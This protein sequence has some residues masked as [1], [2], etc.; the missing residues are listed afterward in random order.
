MDTSKKHEIFEIE[1]LDS[2]KSG[3]F[4]EP[5]VFG[6][7]TM[8]RLC[9]ELNRYSVDLDFWFIRK[10]DY[11]TYFKKLRTYLE[12]RYDLTY[13]Q[14][15]SNILLFE[16]RSKDYQKRLKIEIRREIKSCDYQEKIA[17]SKC[18]TKQ[19]LL[20][21][22]TLEQTMKNKIEAALDRAEIRDFFDIEFM[23]RNGIPLTATT[24]QKDLMAKTIAGFKASD[25][26]VKLG[27]LLDPETRRYYTKNQFDYLLNKLRQSNP[28]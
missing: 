22:H 10:T 27:A 24:A 4:L 16:I 18:H 26:S 17:F 9:Y 5:L 8:L 21:V 28:Q 25:Y 19:V 12:S 6:G 7:G 3:K 2:L 15:K 23:L 14:T 13:A 1:T 20:R 11:N